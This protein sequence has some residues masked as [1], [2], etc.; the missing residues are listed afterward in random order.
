MDH[1]GIVYSVRS[2][3]NHHYISKE[4]YETLE[5]Q[6][7]SLLIAHPHIYHVERVPEI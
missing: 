4:D 5:Q 3:L 6:W 2:S 1:T 7:M